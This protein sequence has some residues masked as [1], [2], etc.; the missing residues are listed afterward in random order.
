MVLALPSMRATLAIGSED[1]SGHP[2][3]GRRSTL[4]RASSS[5]LPTSRRFPQD[6][7]ALGQLGVSLRPTSETPEPSRYQRQLAEAKAP[8]TAASMEHL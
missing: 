6:R 2:L 3:G 1:R 7:S 8:A 5:A 4:V